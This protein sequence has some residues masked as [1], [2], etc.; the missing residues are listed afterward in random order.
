MTSNFRFIDRNVDISKILKQVNDNPQD[1]QAVSNY[2]NIG[3]NLHPPG[4]LPLVM[5]VVSSPDEDPKDS[6]ILQVTPMMS[7]YDEIVRWLINQGFTNFSRAAFFKLAPGREVT[8][9]IDD[10][11]YY[12]TKD[13]Y[14]LSLQGTY[15]Y[16]VE[17]EVQIITPGTFFW[18]DNKKQHSALNIGDDDRITFVFDVP[19]SASNP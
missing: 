17:D 2:E 19:H 5:A 13:R 10:G 3:G 15:R 4:F 12:L 7:K 8:T 18:F 16:I 9:H 1:W 6:E 14:H 11:T